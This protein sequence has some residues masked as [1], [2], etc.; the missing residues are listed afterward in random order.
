MI[1][2]W[3]KKKW[4]WEYCVE[5][6]NDPKVV[7]FYSYVVNL[8]RTVLKICPKD[9]FQIFNEDR[10]LKVNEGDNQKGFEKKFFAPDSAP[11]FIGIVFSIQ[12]KDFSDILNDYRAPWLK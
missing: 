1:G 7:S 9:F 3:S 10:V 6:L 11:N 12:T 4:N 8:K 2:H 5:T